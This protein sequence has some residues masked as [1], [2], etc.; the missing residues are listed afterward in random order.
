MA[1]K[2]KVNPQ[3]RAAMN[4]ATS[5]G[6][7]LKEA[8]RRVKSGKRSGGGGRKK[9]K[10]AKSNPTSNES[11]R[12]GFG[13]TYLAGSRIQALTSPLAAEVLESSREAEDLAEAFVET[14]QKVMTADYATLGLEVL[15]DTYLDK[16]MGQA[17]AISGKSVTAIA[18]E[19][20][21]ALLTGTRAKAGG[22]LNEKAR[23][24]NATF[25]RVGFGYRPD[26]GVHDIMTPE[27]LMFRKIKHGGQAVRFLRSRF[28]VVERLTEPIS[29][30]LLRP[31]GL[32]W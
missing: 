25:A 19:I 8:W 1:K 9:G 15:A 11:R 4:L 29:K 21:R 17:R 20:Y 14:Q 27:H 23:N 12:P 30:Y 22:T 31:L 10:R 5:K 7:S 24:A 28:P 16:K 26:A 13:S 18:P 2:R 3:A 32:R 6:I